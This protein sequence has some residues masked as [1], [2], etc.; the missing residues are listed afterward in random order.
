LKKELKEFYRKNFKT[1][2]TVESDATDEGTGEERKLTRTY[3]M[4]LKE[5]IAGVSFDQNQ[6]YFHGT[7]GD[8]VTIEI[9]TPRSVQISDPPL[10]HNNG[11]YVIACP[12]LDDDQTVYRTVEMKI[13]DSPLTIE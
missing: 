9:N 7:T 12:D 2:L 8:H 1:D 4:S 5:P 3:T 13:T 6:I 10:N 11:K